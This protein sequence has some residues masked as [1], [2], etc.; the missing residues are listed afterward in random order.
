MGKSSPHHLLQTWRRPKD[1]QSGSPAF[2]L[3]EGGYNLFVY[4]HFGKIHGQRWGNAELQELKGGTISFC[5]QGQPHPFSWGLETVNLTE[6][7]VGPTRALPLVAGSELIPCDISFCHHKWL[8]R[9][10]GQRTSWGKTISQAATWSLV[11]HSAHKS[12]QSPKWLFLNTF[13]SLLHWFAH[14]VTGPSQATFNPLSFRVIVAL[15][16]PQTQGLGF[17]RFFLI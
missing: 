3:E 8:H 15:I 14:L 12:T 5:S 6:H 4:Y 1:A 2:L 7:K 13:L 16:Y 17:G 11:W 10:L 9:W